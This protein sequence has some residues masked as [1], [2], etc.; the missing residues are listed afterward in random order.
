[1]LSSDLVQYHCVWLSIQLIHFYVLPLT[2]LLQYQKI[3]ATLLT[4]MYVLL[5]EYLISL[6]RLDTFVINFCDKFSSLL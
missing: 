1:M 4:F 5:Q 3:F 6:L 2:K